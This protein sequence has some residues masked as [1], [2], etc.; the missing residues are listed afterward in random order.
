MKKGETRDIQVTFPADYTN[1]EIAGKDAR[2]TV[3]LKEIKKKVL[4][5][6]NDEFAKDTGGNKTVDELKARSGKI[7][8]RE[9]ATSRGPPSVRN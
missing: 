5:E 6:L 3:T 8:R 2:F 1:K 4:P 7:S 9:S